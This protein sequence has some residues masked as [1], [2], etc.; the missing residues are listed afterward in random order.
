MLLSCIVWSVEKIQKAKTKGC[1][2]KLELLLKCVVFDSKKTRII[3]KEA[4]GLSSSLG[5]KSSLS[6]IPLVGHILF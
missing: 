1:K 5:L 3:K 4:S 2:R 6:K